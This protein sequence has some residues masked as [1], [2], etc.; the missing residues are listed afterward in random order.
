MILTK[1]DFPKKEINKKYNKNNKYLI[2]ESKKPTNKYENKYIHKRNMKNID[3]S[4]LKDVLNDKT[5]SKNNRQNNETKNENKKTTP[6]NLNGGVVKRN[7]INSVT[8]RNKFVR[9]QNKNII[10]SLRGMETE[11]NVYN[12]VNNNLYSTINETKKI[13]PKNTSM[14]QRYQKNDDEIFLSEN[15]VRDGKQNQIYS[16]PYKYNSSSS[17]LQ[18]NFENQFNI[19]D[20]KNI[21]NINYFYDKSGQNL[22][23][24]DQMFYTN[25]YK[26]KYRK[27]IKVNNKNKYNSLIMK[28]ENDAFSQE[29]PTKTINS[30][31]IRKNPIN[32]VKN[33]NNNIIIKDD[34]TPNKQYFNRIKYIETEEKNRI[35]N[36]RPRH[37][38]MVERNNMNYSPDR[39]YTNTLNNYINN[40]AEKSD[41]KIIRRNGN[42]IKIFKKNNNTSIQEY[43]LS[44]GNEN[45]SENDDFDIDENDNELINNRNKIRYILNN[46]IIKKNQEINEINNYYKY[47]T[48]NIIPII[49]SQFSIKN[50]NKSKINLPTKNFINVNKVHHNSFHKRKIIP[51]KNNYDENDNFVGTPNFSQIGKTPKNNNINIHNKEL[52]SLNFNENKETKLF[53]VCQNEKIEII[54]K[55][56]KEENNIENKFVF[57]TEEEII[58][59]VYKKFEEERKKKSYFNRKLRFTGFILTKKYK[60]KNLYDIRIEDDLEQINQKLKD[61]NVLI[62]DKNVELNYVEY[63]NRLKSLEEENK[64]LKEEINNLKKS[65]NSENELLNQKLENEKQ[66]INE[67]K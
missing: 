23:D 9:N 38:S 50:N 30:F 21:L 58:D 43:N 47:F 18:K 2:K 13:R 29:I 22:E 1:D 46:N 32:L 52:K 11:Y 57:K 65:N 62:N 25:F 27:R 8:T 59:Y 55:K 54:N 44:L 16:R 17:E 28:D 6:L 4:S 36:I 33:I 10:D 56:N 51:N 19:K 24:M 66:N 67:G 3:Y 20:A 37:H 53:K 48:K 45:D 60:G 14:E 42:K 34:E 39:F 15:K 7:N 64:K 5:V 63:L 31:Y 41:R 12:K 26:E 40:K 35:N 49:T 61:E